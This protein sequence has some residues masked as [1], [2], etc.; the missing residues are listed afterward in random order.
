MDRLTGTAR[1]T[2]EQAFPLVPTHAGE[3]PIGTPSFRRVP[4]RSAAWSTCSD[5]D[6]SRT[7]A[8]SQTMG[9]QARSSCLP[10]RRWNLEEVVARRRGGTS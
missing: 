4:S 2:S 8:A 5:S 10:T 6:R 7:M 9:E 1:N 3:E